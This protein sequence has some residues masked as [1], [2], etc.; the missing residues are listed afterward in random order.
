MNELQ[1]FK[2][3]YQAEVKKRNVSGRLRSGCE[4]GVGELEANDRSAKHG[5]GAFEVG[6]VSNR[7]SLDQE[8]PVAGTKRVSEARP[9][10][11]GAWSAV[12]EAEMIDEHQI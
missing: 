5:E 12:S 10:E 8:L 1:K 11:C 4:G 2:N 9:A 3:L 6:A 7:R